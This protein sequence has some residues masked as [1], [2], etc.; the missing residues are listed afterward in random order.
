MKFYPT[1][2]DSNMANPTFFYKEP[3]NK[4]PKYGKFTMEFMTQLKNLN[5]LEDSLERINIFLKKDV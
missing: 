1:I 5:K 2:K 3:K 4:G